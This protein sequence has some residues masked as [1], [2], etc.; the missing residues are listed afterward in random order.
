MQGEFILGL[1]R[2]VTGCLSSS[3]VT[4]VRALRSV[5]TLTAV[6][7]E[8]QPASWFHQLGYGLYMSLGCQPLCR[9]R[10]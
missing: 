5:C 10:F 2:R 7:G 1:S 6:S 8:V 4:H 9:G 3:V